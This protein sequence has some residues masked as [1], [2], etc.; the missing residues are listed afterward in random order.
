MN[1]SNELDQNKGKV[2]KVRLNV[3]PIPTDDILPGVYNS[4][5]FYD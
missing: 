1:K 2:Y 3:I 4:I 5:K